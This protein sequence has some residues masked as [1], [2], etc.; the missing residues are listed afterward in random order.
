MQGNEA[1][2]SRLKV[3]AEEGNLPN[4]IIAGPPG[5]GKTTSILCLARQML[6]DSYKD[7]V[8]EMNAS[9]DRSFYSCLKYLYVFLDNIIILYNVYNN[10]SI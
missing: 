5:A 1:T 7:A 6:G 4:I 8:L 9:N 10:S 2:V 3:I